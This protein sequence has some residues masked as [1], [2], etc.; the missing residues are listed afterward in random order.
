MGEIA[1]GSSSLEGLVGW[2]YFRGEGGL[3]FFLSRGYC[4]VVVLPWG[5]EVHVSEGLAEDLC[6]TWAEVHGGEGLAGD[7][8]LVGDEPV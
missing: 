3:W 4:W 7:F 6:V 2:G 5:D 1:R 8:H